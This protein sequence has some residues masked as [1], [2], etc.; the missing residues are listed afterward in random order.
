MKS[1]NGFLL[2]LG[3]PGIGKTYF[4]SALLPWIHWKVNNYYYINERNYLIR[5]REC[6]DRGW[7]Y[8]K[9]ISQSFDHEF[10]M[11]D[12]LGSTGMNDWRVEVIFGLIDFRYE[13]RKPT[14][15]TSNLTRKTLADCLGQRAASRLFASE[16][17][18]IENHE[19]QD[20]RQKGM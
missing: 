9:E 14:V 13:N 4:C 7:D 3:A 10:L 19:G 1:P 20:L 8:S 18:I 16:N 2:Y 15:F 5:L 12:D 11:F 17:L 6:I